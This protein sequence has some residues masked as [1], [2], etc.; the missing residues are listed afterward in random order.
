[1]QDLDQVS[2]F[3]QFVAA[4]VKVANDHPIETKKVLAEWLTHLDSLYKTIKGAMTPY[5]QDGSVELTD[6]VIPINEPRIGSYQAKKIVLKIGS[7]EV[8]F[9]PIGTNLIAAK[10]R[11]DIIGP[12]GTAKIVLVDAQASKPS[13]RV[14]ITVKG[15]KKNASEDGAPVAWAWKLATPPPTIRYTELNETTLLQAIMEVANG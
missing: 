3:K 14:A 4:E 13:I 9:V 12:A 8:S 15:E 11:V 5:I 2:R 1:M 10:G 6:Q 7:K